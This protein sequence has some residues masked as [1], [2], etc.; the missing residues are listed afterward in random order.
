M[1]E[2]D[3]Q[4]LLH[5]WDADL[6]QESHLAGRKALLMQL[7]H[8]YERLDITL[9]GWNTVMDVQ[10]NL[11]V[12][13]AAQPPPNDVRLM[14][15][16]TSDT[17]QMAAGGQIE[18]LSGQLGA[19]SLDRAD[20]N[21]QGLRQILLGRHSALLN[22]FVQQPQNPHPAQGLAALLVPYLP[23]FGPGIYRPHHFCRGGVTQGLTVSGG[24]LSQDYTYLARPQP[25]RHAS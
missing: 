2:I 9:D 15:L 21:V 12:S 6:Q 22:R 10:G 3:G 24:P 19:V 1:L 11:V 14:A 25:S 17:L 7:H 8:P 23:V 13:L 4:I 16:P 18:A 5:E 20:R